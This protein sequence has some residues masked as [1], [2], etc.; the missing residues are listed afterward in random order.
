VCDIRDRESQKVEEELEKVEEEQVD[1][2]FPFTDEE[3]VR[4]VR[5]K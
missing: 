5:Q 1:Q 4:L 3:F 2:I